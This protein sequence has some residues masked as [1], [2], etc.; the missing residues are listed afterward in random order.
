MVNVR[1][2]SQQ[3]AEEII[4]YVKGLVDSGDWPAGHRMPTEKHLINQFSAARNTVRKA[5]AEL[6][7]DLVIIR[8]V[9]RGTYVRGE[10]NESPVDE[11]ANLKFD[12][13]SPAE[14][15]EI[16]VLLE[17]AI[18]ELVVARATGSDIAY[19]QTCLAKGL[20]AKN[21]EEYEHWDAELHST[22]INA[23][24]NSLVIGFYNIIHYARQKI[25]WRQIKTKSLDPERVKNYNRQ[26]SD[27]VDSFS[28]RDAVA[29]REAL[30]EHLKTVSHNMLNPI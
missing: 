23:S 6:E 7:K 22:I 5:L 16:R 9:G 18:A 2:A 21:I 15:N 17:P 24:R 29:L 12:D 4:S 3:K 30:K 28:K 19:A 20:V 10:D 25:E 11:K 27:I 13:A 26:H 1:E 14:I 8:Y